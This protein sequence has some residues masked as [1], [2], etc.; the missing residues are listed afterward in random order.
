MNYNGTESIYLP[1]PKQSPYETT[2]KFIRSGFY[3]DL[4]QIG[5]IH[6]YHSSKYAFFCHHSLRNQVKCKKNNLSHNV[7]ESKKEIPGSAV[8]VLHRPILHPPNKF[9]GN[10]K[11]LRRKR[12]L[13]GRG[14]SSLARHHQFKQADGNRGADP[15]DII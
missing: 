2:F 14:N 13:Y 1:R 8:W 10:P 12:N 7:Q 4:H 3:V 11:K 6:E 15:P 9:R 5:Q